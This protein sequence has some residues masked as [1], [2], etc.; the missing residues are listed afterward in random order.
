MQMQQHVPGSPYVGVGCQSPQVQAVYSAAYT[1]AFA[2]LSP[3]NPP[4][5][6]PN[7]VAVPL[8]VMLGAGGPMMGMGVFTVGLYDTAVEF[9]LPVA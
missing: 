9:T 1:A 5:T 6:P 2:S 8:P 4:G 3:G 7:A